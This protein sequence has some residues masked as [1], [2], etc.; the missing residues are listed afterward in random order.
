MFRH[1]ICAM[2]IAASLLVPARAQTK[3]L[4][5]PDIHGNQLVFT[6]EIGRAHV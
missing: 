3:L 4:R 2:A 5:F 1:L 6:Y